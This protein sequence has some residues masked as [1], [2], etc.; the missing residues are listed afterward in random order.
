MHHP[1]GLL[2][3]RTPERV[4]ASHDERLPLTEVFPRLLELLGVRA[5]RPQRTTAVQSG[6]PVPEIS[7][8]PR[9]DVV[10]WTL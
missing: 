10:A 7:T 2:W 1:E 3:I 4:H 8:D 9:T 5:Q 6:P